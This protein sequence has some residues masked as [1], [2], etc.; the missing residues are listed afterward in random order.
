MTDEPEVIVIEADKKPEQLE[1][2]ERQIRVAAYC[3]VSTDDEEQRT[4]YEAQKEYYALKIM[5]NR[6]WIMAGIFADEGLSATSAKKRP[7]FQKILRKC[8]QGKI[9]LILT[10][11]VSRFARNTLD[12]IGITRALREIGVAVYFEK[13]NLNTMEADSEFVLTILG[14]L[15][16]AESENI[17]K[18]VAWGKR[19]AMQSG[20]VMSFNRI[21]G[22]QVDDDGIP[23]IVPEEAEIVRRIYHWYLA[24]ASVEQII[25]RLE[26]ENI[27][28][29][30]NNSRWAQS[31]IR[32]LLRN[33]KYS[34]DVLQQKTFVSDLITRRIVKNNGQL[35]KY[36]IKNYH[37]PIVSRDIFYKVQTEFKRRTSQTTSGEQVHSNYHKYSSKHA[38]AE[39]M[40]CE[41][42]GMP[43]RRAVWTKRSGEKQPVWRCIN[44][45]ENGKEYCKNSP[46]VQEYALQ[47]AI[48]K[49]VQANFSLEDWLIVDDIPQKLA[50]R[51]WS[52]EDSQEIQALKKKL[53]TVL[54][55]AKNED[56]LR[57]LERIEAEIIHLQQAELSL[58]ES[59]AQA[60]SELSATQDSATALQWDETMIRNLVSK[61][62]VQGDNKAVLKFKNGKQV[63]LM[64]GM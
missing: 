2:S 10:K 23:Q 34:G 50:Q 51:Q 21:Y 54:G 24:G 48:L 45:L 17:S 15:A 12:C 58:S 41:E 6:Q 62:I 18:N 37:E 32:S 4:S 61:V 44:R 28:T 13:E 36:L 35:P 60:S 20:K 64:I 5:E 8:K 56:F 16:Q 31:T 43:Y 3:R 59:F 47:D 22:Y 42:C 40:I 25:N 26:E 55:E 27:P 49:A 1:W 19:Q 14:S 7:Q 33:E 63:A 30:T 53:I 9:D 57:S 39:I 38:L 11:S 46:T 52:Y 29:L